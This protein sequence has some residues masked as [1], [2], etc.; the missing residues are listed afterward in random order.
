VP[1]TPESL[2]QELFARQTLLIQ[3]MRL[4]LRERASQNDQT[5]DDIM[6]WAEETKQFFERSLPSG[7]AETYLTGAIDA[8]FNVLAAEV[9]SD[10]ENQKK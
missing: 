10:R 2:L 9:K 7:T 6:K 8:F 3:L 4:L 1:D 5:E